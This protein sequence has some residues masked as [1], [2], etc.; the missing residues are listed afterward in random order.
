M[1]YERKVWCILIDKGANIFRIMAERLKPKNWEDLVKAVNRFYYRH[2]H[3]LL[4]QYIN[5]IKGWIRK[6]AFLVPYSPFRGTEGLFVDR[7][8]TSILDVGCG[9]GRIMNVANLR[10]LS[11][12]TLKV[13]I[14]AFLPYLKRAKCEGLYN[15][16]IL[17][18]I[19]YLPIEKRVLI[20]LCA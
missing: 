7:S 11:K 12:D 18:D 19:R 15:G 6:V 10:R 1:I 8:A 4:N 16:Y 17:C 13:G 20:L 9:D 3:H 2:C 14:D 5:G